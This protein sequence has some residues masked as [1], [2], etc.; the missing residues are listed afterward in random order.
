MPTF[1]RF[2][3]IPLAVLIYA[4]AVSGCAYTKYMAEAKERQQSLNQQLATEQDKG[5]IIQGESTQREIERDQ[6]LSEKKQLEQDLVQYQKRL[7]KLS[8]VPPHRRTVSQQAEIEKLQSQI[9]RTQAS[10]AEKK[11]RLSKELLY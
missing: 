2:A 7:A 9:K 8:S 6:L 4:V 3:R 1:P 11:R 5:E 10:I